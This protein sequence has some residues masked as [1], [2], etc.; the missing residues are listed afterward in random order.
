PLNFGLGGI[1][2]LSERTERLNESPVGELP[3]RP[4]SPSRVKCGVVRVLRFC[5]VGDLSVVKEVV[6]LALKEGAAPVPIIGS[7]IHAPGG[8]RSIG[9]NAG[10]DETLTPAPS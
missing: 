2:R 8:S 1:L 9:H 4:K 7:A 10:V 5:F 3:V 6:N